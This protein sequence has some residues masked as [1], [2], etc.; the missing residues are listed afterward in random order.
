MNEQDR[1]AF[2][3]M[4]VGEALVERALLR[5]CE[6]CFQQGVIT[7]HP[8]ATGHPDGACPVC[9]APTTIQALP[10]VLAVPGAANLLG[11]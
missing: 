8:L 2:A 7:P 11:A 9:G 5:R 3:A 6:P 10:S 1:E 4:S